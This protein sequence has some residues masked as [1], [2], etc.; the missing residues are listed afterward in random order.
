M[1]LRILI[2]ILGFILIRIHH[3]G[4]FTSVDVKSTCILSDSD[5]QHNEPAD[6][7]N[8]QQT[9]EGSIG[10]GRSG[11]ARRKAQLSKS[12]KKIPNI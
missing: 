2:Q 12:T 8:K 10:S 3:G 4:M 5:N 6:H 7:L 11:K 1:V 9:Q